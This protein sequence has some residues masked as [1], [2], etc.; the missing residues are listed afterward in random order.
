L[1]ALSV[2]AA[3]SLALAGCASGSAAP[4][5]DAAHA[6]SGDGFPVTID[7][8]YGSTTI[9]TKP[10]RVAT[11]A[12]G[13]GEVPLALGVVPVGMAK[14]TWGDDDHDGVLPWS[15]DRIA[16]L[17]G[18]TPA[19]YDETD[20]VDF[21]AVAD[22]RPDVILAAYS[23]LTQSD[24]D[25]LSKIAP[26]V[27]YPDTAWGTSYEDMIRMD[28]KAIGL[29]KEGD[30]LI[31]R[32]HGEVDTA[33]ADFPKLADA[34]V[35]FSYIDPAD[36]SKIGF[37]TDHDTRP[38]FLLDL[39]MPEPQVV[40]EESAKTGE[41]YVTVSSEQA[42]RFSDVDLFVTYGDDADAMIKSLQADPLLSKIPAIKAGHIAVLK[43]DTPLAASANPSPLSIGWGIHDYFALLAKA[44]G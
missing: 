15:E 35:L 33:L 39:G 26:V 20:G 13:N 27:A 12:W 42:D 28:A 43:N 9:E 44:L 24:Y 1:A 31:D 3:S 41:F 5:D 40:S 6:A 29:E 16:E 25:T 32:L 18:D 23:G 17:G 30:A 37:Y 38:G 34:K 8:V 10:E 22:T 4:G 2:V 19:L 11:V 7:H 14:T 21:E 36:Y